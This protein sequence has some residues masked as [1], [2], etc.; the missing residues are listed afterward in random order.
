M[1]PY[2]HSNANLL[3][4][5]V[6]VNPHTLLNE[7]G[8]IYAWS[9]GKDNIWRQ[10]LIFVNHAMPG[11]SVLALDDLTEYFTVERNVF[12][13]HGVHSQRRRQPKGRARQHHP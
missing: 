9:T 10:N 8:A 3:E 7:G 6:V 1:K 11:S 12:W 4:K 13:V 2:I 5:N